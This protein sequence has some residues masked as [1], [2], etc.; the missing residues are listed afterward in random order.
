MNASSG[1]SSSSC[2]VQ[3]CDSAASPWR[4][5]SLARPHLGAVLAVGIISL[6]T[7]CKSE[8]SSQTVSQG[9]GQGVSQS[10]SQSQSTLPV[11]SSIPVLSPSPVQTPIPIQSASQIQSPSP[12]PSPI[13]SLIQGLSPSLSPSAPTRQGSPSGLALAVRADRDVVQTLSLGD[14][15]LVDRST[16]AIA[17]LVTPT[18][19]GP[20]PVLGVVAAFGYS[21]RLRKRIKESAHPCD[22]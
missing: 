10:Q 11:P 6:T 8:S 7:G 1:L 5:V 13:Q 14:P 17:A 16:L 9:L 2:T 4:E 20:L 12:S 22:R 19:P 21:H 3:G 18:V 15:P